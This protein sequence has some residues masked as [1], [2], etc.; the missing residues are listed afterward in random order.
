MRRFARSVSNDTRSRLITRVAAENTRLE[1]A[2]EMGMLHS[3]LQ[4]AA[5]YGNSKAFRCQNANADGATEL[6]S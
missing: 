4:S 2:E 5:R 6:T 1:S 3:I